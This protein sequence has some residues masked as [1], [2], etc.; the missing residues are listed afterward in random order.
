LTRYRAALKKRV[1]EISLLGENR[2]FPLDDVFVELTVMEEIHR[3]SARD[4][5]YGLMD[6]VLRRQRAIFPSGE[7]SD[8]AEKLP[9]APGQRPAKKEIRVVK[10]EELLKP[11]VRA[12]VA[13][14]PGC[15]KTTLLRWLANQT[16]KT[17]SRLPIFIELKALPETAFANGET[18]GEV[19]YAAILKRFLN[20]AD[21]LPDAACAAFK[22]HLNEKLRA[23]EVA[24]FL[25]GLDE[26]RERK[27]FDPL[28]TAVDD[29]L[30]SAAPDATLVI[31]TRPYAVAKG[32]TGRLEEMEIAPLDAKQ[33]EAFLTRY[34]GDHADAVARLRERLKRERTLAD[35]ARTPFLLGAMAGLFARG[36]GTATDRLTLYG[37]IVRDLAGRLDKEKGVERFRIDDSD[38]EM[39]REFL[40]EF[41]GARLFDAQET[42]VARRLMFTGEDLKRFAK[43]HCAAHSYLA[44]VNPNSLALDATATPLLREVGTDAYAFAHLTLQEYLAA[45]GLMRRADAKDTLCRAIFNPTLAAMEVLPMALGL[46]EKP[47]EIYAA[48]EDLPE[49]LD[50]ANLRVRA[51]GLDYAG[52]V[53]AQ[54]RIDAL[55]DRFMQFFHWKIAEESP[56]RNAVM[57]SFSNAVGRSQRALTDRLLAAL[58]DEDRYVRRDAAE[59]LGKLGAATLDV[60]N[61]LLAALCDDQDEDVRRYAAEALGKLGAASPDVTAG[62]LTALLHDDVWYVRRD[63][64][65]ALGQLGAATPDVVSG[66]LAALR[67][68]KNA[69]VRRD[70]AAALG[71]LGA[72]TPDVV[73]GLLAALR[74][75]KNASVRRDAAEAL[76]QLGAATPDVVSGLLAALRDDDQDVRRYAVAALGKLGAATPDVVSELLAAL[77]D[78]DQFVRRDAAQA[79]VQLGAATPDVVSGLLAALRDDDQDVRR[80]A[81][82]ALGKL[83]AATPDVVSGLLAALRDDKN[84]YVR[85]YAAEAL[86]KL[87]AATPDVV[88]GLLAALRDDK[89]EWVRRYAAQALGR[90]GTATPD[91]VSGLLAVLRDNNE[92]VRRDAAPALG[93]LGAATPDVVSG[94][95]AVLRDE[96][97]YVRREAAP[98]LGQLGAATPD[99]VSGLLAALRDE[100]SGVRWRAAKALGQLGAASP[101]VTAGLLAALRDEDGYVRREAAEALGQLGAASPEVTAGLLAALRDEDGY[102]RREAAEVLG[103]LG[104]VLPE[105]T[106]F[107]LA[108]LH[109]KQEYVR[110]EAAQALERRAES[111]ASVFHEGL[112]LALTGDDF[113]ARRIAARVIGYYEKD[114]ATLRTLENLAATRF[115][116]NIRTIATDAAA[117]YARK[118]RLFGATPDA[119]GDATAT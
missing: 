56:Y 116:T 87:G 16:L 1:G 69:S 118:L 119:S 89:N 25:D 46:A 81:A 99:V 53:L 40:T 55:A 70:A 103:Q 95:L 14:A 7:K 98:A 60:V 97:G 71:Q 3:P 88:S 33:I 113:N 54:V 42:E 49:S 109:D 77:R 104:A 102:V 64:A 65:A 39:K 37:E 9:P 107:W 15:G 2:T 27:I 48:L 34:F 79:L 83:G 12:V 38:G 92:N 21:A 110:W 96:D 117:R 57:E 85:F 84:E 82:A 74:D 94:L 30:R 36:G 78:D 28:R 76:G 100:N 5:M 13:G 19:L 114:E 32:F 22:T 47:D 61:G 115:N 101:E 63:A 62:F 29:F 23:G 10:P 52:D 86:G 18:L 17:D 66:L 31:S 43:R 20:A 11:S 59:A 111:S 50:F 67:D 93:Q 45:V 51:R 105:V 106:A 6:A 90:L 41:A 75:D 8:D 58:R 73:S 80:Y 112:R 44:S 4:E 68:D 72:A 108:R 26:I 91:V 24:I 35:L